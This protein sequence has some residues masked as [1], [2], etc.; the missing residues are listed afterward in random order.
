MKNY[1]K[2]VKLASE[3][4]AKEAAN[5]AIEKWESE[6]R[7]QAK[8]RVDRRLRNT[9]LLLDNYRSFVAHVQHAVHDLASAG[10]ESAIYILDMMDA[11]DGTESVAI[12]SIKRTTAR[13]AV[14]V[15]H[16]EQMLEVYKV[17]CEASKK[18]EDIRRYRVIFSLFIA[19]CQEGNMSILD[20][21]ER[22]QV[23]QRTIY[24][25]RDIALERLSALFFGIDG[26]QKSK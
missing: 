20:I 9:K 15:A 24:R 1:D 11:Y 21:S 3:T 19:D 7:K 2:I 17:M 26:M 23:D 10:E 14:I 12:E 8:Q 4:A 16:I 25:D 6:K 22:E 18:H 5:V 13:T